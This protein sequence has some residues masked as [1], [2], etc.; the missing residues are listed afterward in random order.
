MQLLFAHFASAKYLNLLFK[1]INSKIFKMSQVNNGSLSWAE[2]LEL[3]WRAPALKKEQSIS[4]EFISRTTL[5][6]GYD[7]SGITKNKLSRKQKIII[8]KRKMKEQTRHSVNYK[9]QDNSRPIL[10]VVLFFEF[11][12]DVFFPQWIIDSCKYFFTL[13]YN[14]FVYCTELVAFMYTNMWRSKIGSLAT[15]DKFKST[16]EMLIKIC[17]A[18]DWKN[19]SK[20]VFSFTAMLQVINPNITFHSKIELLIK[21]LVFS[22][23]YKA[24]SNVLSEVFDGGYKGQSQGFDDIERVWNK[25]ATSDLGIGFAQIAI[26]LVTVGVIPEIDWNVSGIEVFSLKSAQGV[27][28][29]K[30]VY[31]SMKMIIKS[32]ING[33]SNYE[34]TGTFDGFFAAESLE[35][36]V[37]YALSLYQQV[38]IGNLATYVDGMTSE[39]YVGMLEQL[40]AEVEKTMLNPKTNDRF[41]TKCIWT[42]S[43]IRCL[44]WHLFK[45][46][47]KLRNKHLDYYSSEILLL[48][49][50]GLP[51]L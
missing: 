43:M 49:R 42:K 8:D 35:S 25:L 6:D 21:K 40:K 11:L 45:W 5:N 24:H 36:R 12:L 51:F 10:F 26:I 48:E 32:L 2:R 28:N 27:V 18:T 4:T 46:N 15:S 13:M 20:V 33:I 31:K 14:V 50:V 34:A 23:S 37:S 1:I 17:Y 3:E 22:K 29:I 47:N 38:L 7:D 30:N 41:F 39:Q 44:P 19:P 9:G 16:C